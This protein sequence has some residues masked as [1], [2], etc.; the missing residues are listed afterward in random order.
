MARSIKLPD[1]IVAE[2]DVESLLH[3]RSIGGQITHWVKIGRAIE[4]SG[5]FSHDRV[6]AVLAGQAPAAALSDEEHAVWLEKFI[7][8]MGDATPEE[9]AFFAE[10]RKLGRGVGLDR[11]GRLVRAADLP[12]DAD[13]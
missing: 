2:A 6:T 1:D 12:A 4:R 11:T 8:K 3:S 9:E 10:R 7:E 5:R 13:H